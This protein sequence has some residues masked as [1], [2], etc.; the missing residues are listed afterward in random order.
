VSLSSGVFNRP[1][2]RRMPSWSQPS[3]LSNRERCGASRRGVRKLHE[4]S[5]GS[6]AVRR[7]LSSHFSRVAVL[8]GIMQ[9]SGIDS[10]ANKCRACM[11]EGG[12]MLPMYDDKISKINLP[13][14]LAQLTSIQV[15]TLVC[16]R[17]SRD[18]AG[19][20]LRGKLRK[21]ITFLS[22]LNK[23]LQRISKAKSD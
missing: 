12:K 14:K 6:F 13:Y 7:S 19:R 16:F 15:R 22:N 18:F 2:V 10:C 9:S 4:N 8:I 17:I 5:L 3:Q 20:N 23:C 21:Y 11:K 1:S